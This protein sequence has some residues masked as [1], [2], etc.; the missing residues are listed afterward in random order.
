MLHAKLSAS[1]A[2]KWINCPLSVVLESKMP[3]EETP[4]AKEG[5]LAHE[6]S[7][8]K[9][10]RGLNL[11]GKEA[12]ETEIIKIYYDEEMDKYTDYYCDV[13]MEI[14]NK[15][16]RNYSTVRLEEKVDFSPWV[17]EGFGTSD[18]VVISDN[19]TLN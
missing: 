15:Y 3:N 11:I 7:E 2:K 4:Y 5:T 10:K 8:L 16:D 14:V 1:G 12:Y 18:V 6:L 13:V 9:L 17:P 19:V